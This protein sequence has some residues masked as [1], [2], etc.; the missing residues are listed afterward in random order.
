MD[1]TAIIRLDRDR[2][3]SGIVCKAPE[4]ARELRHKSC[5]ARMIRRYAPSGQ[6]SLQHA[7]SITS[8]RKMRNKR[9]LRQFSETIVAGWFSRYHPKPQD[10]QQDRVEQEKRSRDWTPSGV[11]RPGKTHVPGGPNRPRLHRMGS[12]PATTGVK[13]AC[14][15]A[16]VAVRGAAAVGFSGCRF[17]IVEVNSTS[18]NYRAAYPARTNSLKNPCP[19]GSVGLA[20]GY[21]NSITR[22]R[23][24][25]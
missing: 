3:V 7:E 9:I 11:K 10:F 16:A 12:K 8:R 14:P 20:S 19:Q 15:V 4:N 25:R 6:R 1:I 13:I 21:S 23:A 5:P 17:R 18:T 24:R 2:L 22:R